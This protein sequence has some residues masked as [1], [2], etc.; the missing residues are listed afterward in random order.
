MTKSKKIMK[1]EE[2][3]WTFC[4]KCYSIRFKYEDS[5]GTECCEDCG[6]TDLK[7]STFEE[8]DKLYRNRYGHPYLEDAGLV[9]KSPIFLLTDEQLKTRLF[10]H[11]D[12][13]RIC[14]EL[15]PAFP[16]GLSKEDAV[17]LLFSKLVNDNRLDALRMNLYNRTKNK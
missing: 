5:L 16:G 7:T 9:K 1:E 15:Y 10:K 3:P 8:W 6:C 4:P 17:L 11:P 12:C 14:K 2:D 13:M